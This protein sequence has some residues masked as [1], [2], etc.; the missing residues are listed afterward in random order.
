MADIYV[1]IENAAGEAV[2]WNDVPIGTPIFNRESSE[3]IKKEPNDHITRN[4]GTTE[5]W[6]KTPPGKRLYWKY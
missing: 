4:F 1:R 6:N 2:D 5:D 3:M